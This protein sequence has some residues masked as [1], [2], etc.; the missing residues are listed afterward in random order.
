MPDKISMTVED[1]GTHPTSLSIQTTDT[2]GSAGKDGGSQDPRK[3]LLW[4]L[5]G[6]FTGF[7]LLG[8]GGYVF[9]L[10]EAEFTGIV[11][12]TL[13]ASAIVGALTTGLM[14]LH[15]SLTGRDGGVKVPGPGLLESAMGMV[16][17]A[18]I[19]SVAAIAGISSAL[20]AI[21]SV[22]TGL[23][24][25]LSDTRHSLD[26]LFTATCTR[27]DSLR[28]TL[29]THLQTQSGPDTALW[30]RIDRMHKE[31]VAQV[32]RTAERES[33]EAMELLRLVIAQGGEYQRGIASRDSA[34][35]ERLLAAVQYRDSVVRLSHDILRLQQQ[36]ADAT[37][38]INREL[39]WQASQGIVPRAVGFVFGFP[40]RREEDARI[41][42]T[43]VADAPADSSSSYASRVHQS[44]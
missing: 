23:V 7:L 3:K 26:S 24:T 4:A 37:T 36:N 9:H 35:A 6:S 8:A 19:A 39:K 40:D 32:S 15:S 31:H 10:Y 1:S 33:R 2:G 21:L 25:Q 17:H 28:N 22:S 41:L 16:K 14:I 18:P 30:G 29:Q 5:W 13:I 27:I 42:P 38:N 12:T 34:Y 43:L 20:T 11:R 44:R